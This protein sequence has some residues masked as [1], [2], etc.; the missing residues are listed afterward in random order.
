MGDLQLGSITGLQP[1]T[2]IA[3]QLETLGTGRTVLWPH[4]MSK[5]QAALRCAR[6]PISGLAVQLQAMFGTKVFPNLMAPLQ[7]GGCCGTE[8]QYLKVYITPPHQLTPKLPCASLYVQHPTLHSCHLI[9]PY[10][11][12]F[13]HPKPPCKPPSPDLVNLQTPCSFMVLRFFHSSMESWEAPSP[14]LAVNTASACPWTPRD[15]AVTRPQARRTSSS[16][17]HSVASG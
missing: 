6:K 1:L 9:L 8:A 5:A 14:T 4:N 7:A 16:L 13:P 10:L 3:S 12:L 2:Y 11:S 17:D 15:P